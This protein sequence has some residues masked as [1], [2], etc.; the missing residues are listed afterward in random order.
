MGVVYLVSNRNFPEPFVLKTFQKDELNSVQ[1]FQIEAKAWISIG[2]HPNIVQAHFVENLSEQLFIGAEYISP[3]EF[4]RNTITDYL[5]QGTTS[6]QNIIKWTAQFCYG[7]AY[8]IS[9]GLKSHRDVKPENLMVDNEGNL[10]ITDFGLSKFDNEFDL[11]NRKNLPLKDLHKSPNSDF[12]S[13][14]F[15][16]KSIG[17]TNPGSFL[18]TILYASPEQ[19]LDASK[20][21]ARSDIY[22]F[23]VVLYQLLGEYPY[24]LKGKT[25][26]EHYAI[27][28]LT[29]PLVKINHPLSDIAYKCLSRNPDDRYQSFEEIIT[30][31]RQIATVNNFKIPTNRIYPDNSLKELYIQSLSFISLG[32]LTRAQK[33]IDK[34]LEQDKY[35]SSAW[36]LK[37]RIEYELGNTDE[38]I[39]A[40]LA[41]YQLDPINSKTCNNL[42]LFYKNN[43]DSL[44][45]IRFLTE[46][47]EIDPYNTGALTNLAVALEEKENFPLA[48]DLIVRAL[49]LA[50][51]KKTLHFNASNIAAEV[52]RQGHYDKA[53]NILELLTKVD[54]QNT[55]NWFNLAS[56]YWLTNQKIKA[57]ECFKI[58]EEQLPNDEQTL[59]SL[60][61]LYGE[62]CN[63]AIAIAYC[64]KLLDKNL[65]TLNAICWRAQ[66]I[67]A[68][69]HGQEAIQFMKSVIS[70]NPTNDHLYVTLANIYSTEGEHFKAIETIQR[71]RQ[72]LKDIGEANNHEKMNFLTNKEAQFRKFATGL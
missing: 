46:S 54:F 4:G 44:S 6:T 52:S 51:D 3:D 47:I 13:P 28:H 45:A 9:K 39:E 18:G 35:D 29:E 32:D 19:I 16:Q 69:G 23:G 71:A 59:V 58:V 48:A 33:L 7:M 10:K 12:S 41:S 53:I 20:V 56:N 70:N 1:R 66:F 42:G 67:Q 49:Q 37:G 8:A 55:N 57:I 17:L 22:S 60:A 38:G 14:I 25:T 64:E 50:P 2:I 36:S 15:Q 63:Y 26:I 40:T 65:S 62:T 27:M 24:S 72:I 34:Y 61:K 11:L 43:G 31:L 68:D 5:R 30:A 21:D